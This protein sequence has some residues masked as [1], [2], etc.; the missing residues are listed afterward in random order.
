MR[1]K[2]SLTFEE[3]TIPIIRARAEA[4]GLELSRWVE[5]ASLNE[6]ARSAVD[7]IEAMYET[8]PPEERA[9]T[10]ALEA[11]DRAVLPE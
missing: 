4:D 9:A 8:L 11:L 2:T 7:D 3:T 1:V 5:R 6:A 10:A